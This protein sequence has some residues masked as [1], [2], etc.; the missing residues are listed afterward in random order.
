MARNAIEIGTDAEDAWGVIL[1]Q[2]ERIQGLVREANEQ[3][4]ALMV[5]GA[6]D[7]EDAEMTDE[8]VTEMVGQMT[9]VTAFTKPRDV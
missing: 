2:F 7:E 3:G 1:A 6:L 8:D 5:R 4:L 9:G